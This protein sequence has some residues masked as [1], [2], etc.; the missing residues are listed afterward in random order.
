MGLIYRI[1]PYLDKHIPIK[2]AGFRNNHGCVEQVFA[3]TKMIEAGFQRKLKRNVEFIDLS[4]AYVIVW[5]EGL[6]QKFINILPC[7]KMGE[8]LNDM[9]VNRACSKCLWM[10]RKVGGA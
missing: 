1:Q 8:L 3:L 9:L 7:K 6:M 4:A 2:Q 10:E 5:R